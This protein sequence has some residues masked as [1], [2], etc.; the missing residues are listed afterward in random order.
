MKNLVLF[1]TIYF[2]IIPQTL[3]KT[4]FYEDYSFYGTLQND[5]LLTRKNKPREIS[6][7]FNNDSPYYTEFK[8]IGEAYYTK[9]GKKDAIR[10]NFNKLQQKK[11]GYLLVSTKALSIDSYELN[12]ECIL[13][14]SRYKNSFQ[15]I[16]DYNKE[17]VMF[18]INRY[19]NNPTMG[20]PTANTFIMLLEPVYA[21]VGIWLFAASPI[22]ALIK[23]PFD[24]SIPDIKKGAIIE[25]QFLEE[26]DGEELELITK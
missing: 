24:G 13:K 14:K 15:G 6:I 17:F 26:I 10:L 3:A 20:K 1:F 16:N 4:I 22:V 23:M 19:K 12:D 8:L 9:L 11:E 21:F 18:P 25:F 2:L 5:I 7:K